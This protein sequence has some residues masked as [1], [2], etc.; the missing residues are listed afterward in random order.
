MSWCT[1]S[2]FKSSKALRPFGNR[3][4]SLFQAHKH[5]E[6][7]QNIPPNESHSLKY[8][9]TLLKT[10]SKGELRQLNRFQLCNDMKTLNKAKSYTEVFEI[11]RI[12]CQNGL[13]LHVMARNQVIIALW[14][15]TS[16]SKYGEV[17]MALVEQLLDQNF[18]IPRQLL[19]SLS[20]M[21]MN[22]RDPFLRFRFILLCRQA[23]FGEKPLSE[24]FTKTILLYANTNE[25]EQAVSL[26]AEASSLDVDISATC[27]EVMI[28]KLLEDNDIDIALQLMQGM[29]NNQKKPIFTR[30]WGHFVAC[31]SELQDYTALSWSFQNCLKPG[32]VLPTDSV[33]YNMADTGIHHGDSEMTLYAIK[34][35]CNRGLHNDVYLTTLAIEMFAKE[36]DLTRAFKTMAFLG[37]DASKIRLR[38]LPILLSKLAESEINM[39][40][41]SEALLRSSTNFSCHPHART[42]IMNITCISFIHSGQPELGSRLYERMREKN[43]QANED[44]FLMLLEK[45]IIEG[46]SLGMEDLYNAFIPELIQ[47]SNLVHEALVISLVKVQSPEKALQWLNRFRFTNLKPRAHVVQ[48]VSEAIKGMSRPA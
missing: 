3:F 33:Y 10:M 25:M 1:R 16:D 40:A 24:I 27:Y 6:F 4:T 21:I 5:R 19:K 45:Y 11:A 35:L 22:T 26:I 44:T 48:I 18:T 30:L 46:S 28:H 20:S 7:H 8:S 17:A 29:L 42:L 31:A 38:D 2:C 15:C 34:Q 13:D 41:A 32:I 12:L 43:Y 9:S 39:T 37:E 36:N 14:G 47:P 23:E